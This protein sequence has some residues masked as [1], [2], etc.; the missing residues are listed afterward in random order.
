M[1][2]LEAFHLCP[3]LILQLIKAFD[4]SSAIRLAAVIMS[5][6]LVQPKC[7]Q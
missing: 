6:L 1:L 3:S 2:C 7:R 5:D 4:A